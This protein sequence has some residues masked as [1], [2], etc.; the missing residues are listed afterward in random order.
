MPYMYSGYDLR[1][2]LGQTAEQV[3]ATAPA[4]VQAAAG[5]GV[6]G[7]STAAWAVPVAG[8]IAATA[9]LVLSWIRR[10]NAQ[11]VA[12]THVVD[13][14]EPYL[15]ENRDVFLQL[16]S[17]GLATSADQAQALATFDAIWAQVVRECRRPE[18]GGAGE[19][20]V[21]ERAAGGCLPNLPGEC[22]NW[23]TL[24]RLPIE[25]APVR[26]AAASA[27]GLPGLLGSGELSSPLFAALGVGL[28]A[29]AVAL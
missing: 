14:A 17:Q 24:Y 15:A 25:T 6:L 1:Q 21:S 23:F 27:A 2:G 19:R 11:K 4:G 5:A 12:A 28:L 10:R 13:D 22:L 8:A 3:I 29:A 9:L 26:P 18:L 7:A 16:A 20:C